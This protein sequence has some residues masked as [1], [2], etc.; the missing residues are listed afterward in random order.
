MAHQHQFAVERERRDAAQRQRPEH[1]ARCATAGE[2]KSTGADT[3]RVEDLDALTAIGRVGHGE[4]AIK[5]DVK[6]T[7]LD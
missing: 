2:Q 4:A 7:R 1:D 5:G 3:A 6:R